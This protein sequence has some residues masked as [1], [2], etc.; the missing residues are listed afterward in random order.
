MSH[1][2]HIDGTIKVCP[3]GKTQAE[4]RYVLE[5]VLA[6]LPQ[7]TGSDGNMHV[8][9]IQE[10]GYDCSSNVNEFDE[11]MTYKG[12]GTDWLRT[13]SKYI[14]ALEADLRDRE[15]DQT[16]REFN[17]WITRLAKRLRISKVLVR[18][19][20]KSH[21]YIFS[22]SK[23]Y[24]DL[25]EPPSWFE[26]SGGEPAWTEYLQW[27][28]AKGTRYPMKLA[29]KYYEDFENDREFERRFAYEHGSN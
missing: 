27:D 24:A 2:T 13:Q 18:I 5:T 7:V 16:F 12:F 20:D 22:N 1:W 23:A 26:E 19:D 10:H 3:S 21:E 25:V 4:K 15:F 17:K 14:L 9:I 28:P 8:H 6:H 11:P 29:Y